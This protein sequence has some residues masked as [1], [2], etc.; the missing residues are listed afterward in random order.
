M[1]RQVAIRDGAVTTALQRALGN[2][3]GPANTQPAAP[4]SLVI[5]SRA[6]RYSYGFWDGITPRDQITWYIQKV[7]SALLCLPSG[8]SDPFC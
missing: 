6:S 2:A 8:M 5:Q 3:P 7:R 4:G 1:V